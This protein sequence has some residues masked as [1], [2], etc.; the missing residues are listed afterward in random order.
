[1]TPQTIF[2]ALKRLKIARKKRHRFI[3]KVETRAEIIEK[4]ETIT[5][6]KRIYLDQSRI[7]QYLYRQYGR[8]IKGKQVLGEISEQRFTR[9][10]IIS[11]LQGKK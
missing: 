4:I 3:R 2:Y 5:P 7:N 10:S 11:A 1:L 9:Q 6:E 8:R